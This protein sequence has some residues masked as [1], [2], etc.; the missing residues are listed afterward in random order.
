M[1]FLTA[2]LVM[3]VVAKPR[4]VK[5]TVAIR[6]GE[7]GFERSTTSRPELEVVNSRSLA[8][9]NAEISAPASASEPFTLMSS[10]PLGVVE[11]GVAIEELSP[12]KPHRRAPDIVARRDL[13]VV[14]I[15]RTQPGVATFD[16]SQEPRSH[17][18]LRI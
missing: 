1:P 12:L 9:S 6:L 10:A 17:P 3:S 14:E 16:G 11:I 13:R 2:T 15:L 18:F 4:A 8:A 5:S 7:A